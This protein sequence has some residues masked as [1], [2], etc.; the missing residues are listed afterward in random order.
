MMCGYMTAN[1]NV[2]GT[3]YQYHYPTFQSLNQNGIPSQ[4][5][6]YPNSDFQYQNQSVARQFVSMPYAPSGS[7]LTPFQS[8]MA[9]ISPASSHS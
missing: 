4:Q 8:Y 2:H 5:A 3:P 6:Q 9:P 7:S 1:P